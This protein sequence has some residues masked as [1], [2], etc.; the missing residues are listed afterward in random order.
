LPLSRTACAILCF[1]ATAPAQTVE[2]R[3]RTTEAFGEY[4]RAVEAGVY[5]RTRGAK[6]FLWTDDSAE[7]GARLRQGEIVVEPL[8]GRSGLSI[9]D[10]LVHDWIGAVFVK[11]AKLADALRSAQDYGRHKDDRLPE[12][13]DTR[14][15]SHSG[16]DYCV[17]MRLLKKKVLTV[18]LDTEHQ[19]QYHELGPDRWYSR[20]ETTRISEV[21]RAGR[22]GERT[23]PP[24]AGHGFLWKLNSYWRFAE[25]DGG[26]YIECEAVSLSRS[27]PS[28][29]GWL[30]EPIAR[31]LP[32]DSLANTLRA[33]RDRMCGGRQN[34]C[35]PSSPLPRR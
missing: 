15:V 31:Q 12:V 1:T 20:S 24:G 16:N 13:I 34:C 27:I 32:R 26:V 22:P 5:E 19:I 6:P 21:E 35:D 9:P 3:P 29:W 23:L 30:I 28:G 17:H 10:G 4:V 7:R 14:I 18:V 8:A 11:G 25:R 2:P 33:M